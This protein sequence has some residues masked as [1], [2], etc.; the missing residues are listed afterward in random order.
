[1]F[2]L[3]P[4][5]HPS[6]HYLSASTRKGHERH[7]VTVSM[8]MTDD[9]SCS[10]SGLLPP[11]SSDIWMQS[12][13]SGERFADR[14][15]FVDFHPHQSVDLGSW[16]D[17]NFHSKLQQHFGHLTGVSNDFSLGKQHG[18]LR[19]AAP[20]SPCV[21][22]CVC[23][24]YSCMRVFVKVC[25]FVWCLRVCVNVRVCKRECVCFWEKTNK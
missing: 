22:V 18:G 15:L 11:T 6:C 23:E 13:H 8:V 7:L 3:G 12:E 24:L 21:R 4:S 5:T 10:M 9:T 14:W 1:M 2:P 17:E 16:D 25:E 19:W 20:S